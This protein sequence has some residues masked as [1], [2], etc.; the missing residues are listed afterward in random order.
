MIWPSYFKDLASPCEYGF[1]DV[2]KQRICDYHTHI[3]DLLSDDFSGFQEEGIGEAIRSLKLR[4][5]A[6][7]NDIEPEHLYYGGLEL[8]SLSFLTPSF[9]QLTFFLHFRLAWSSQSLK[10]ILNSSRILLIIEVLQ[11]SPI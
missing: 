5:A 4:K 8:H 11:F 1:N 6:G 9:S 7:P 3:K 2:F 10:A